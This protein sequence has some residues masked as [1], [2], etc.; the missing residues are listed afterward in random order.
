[1][2]RARFTDTPAR[3]T[4]VD[5]WKRLNDEP[6]ARAGLRRCRRPQEAAYQASY[7][8]LREGLSPHGLGGPALEIVSIAA[9]HVR[10]PHEQ[11]TIASALA[12]QVN[13]RPIL[14][15]LRFRR[16]M[17]IEDPQVLAQAAVR[18]IKR[19]DGKV[20]LADLAES[21]YWWND[22][23]KKRWAFAYYSKL[24]SSQTQEE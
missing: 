17:R 5:W 1:M 12:G 16:L 22:Q 10:K 4:L 7:H 8:D 2:Q 14:T 3:D 20:N 18:L 11:E 23:T 24:S 19:L 15:D 13:G 6:G 21:L 9:A